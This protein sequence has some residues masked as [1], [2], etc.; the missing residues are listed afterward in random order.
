[1]PSTVERWLDI[2]KGFKNKF[3]HC[4]SPLDGKHILVVNPAHNGSECFNYKKTFSIVLLALVDKLI[5]AEM[6]SHGRL[7]DG[8]VFNNS[9]LWEKICRNEIN[10]PTPCPLPGS[11]NDCHFSKRKLNQCLSR[12]RVAVENTFGILTSVF[13]IFRRPIDLNPE[14]VSKSTVTC[15]HGIHGH[16]KT[17]HGSESEIIHSY[18]CGICNFFIFTMT[19]PT[20]MDLD[21]H[22]NKTEQTPPNP[23]RHCKRCRITTTEQGSV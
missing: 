5:F 11:I 15:I 6:R 10:F 16:I 17:S 22:M 2:E 19:N 13:R 18:K 7:S 1:I 3:S 9:F 21:N 4:L 23:T 20:V 14:I 12:S 8:V